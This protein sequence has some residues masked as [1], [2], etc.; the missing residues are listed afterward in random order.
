[1]NRHTFAQKGQILKILE[2]QIKSLH[3]MLQ[4][5]GLDEEIKGPIRQEYIQ[6]MGRYQIVSAEGN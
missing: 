5:D 3:S 6:T 1:M 2:I 4:M